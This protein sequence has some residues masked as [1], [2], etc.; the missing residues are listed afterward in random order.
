[1]DS[2]DKADIKNGMEE[3]SDSLMAMSMEQI[4]NEVAAQ[5]TDFMVALLGIPY[6]FSRKQPLDGRQRLELKEMIESGYYQLSE[7]IDWDSDATNKEMFEMKKMMTEYLP[8][9]LERINLQL[10]ADR[11]ATTADI[12]AWTPSTDEL[13]K[14]LSD[15]SFD[16]IELLSAVYNKQLREPFLQGMSQAGKRQMG[17]L[18]N[19]DLE[20]M[21]RR[22]TGLGFGMV[23]CGCDIM[24]S[25]A[26]AQNL[27]L[28]EQFT[29]LLNKITQA[30]AIP[31]IPS[32]GLTLRERLNVPERYL[33][34]IKRRQLTEAEAI[35][36]L[37]AYIT[38]DLQQHSQ[39][40]SRIKGIM[41]A[42]EKEKWIK[43]AEIDRRTQF[44]LLQRTFRE[45][46]QNGFSEDTFRKEGPR[47]Q[48]TAEEFREQLTNLFADI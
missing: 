11:Q 38:A 4:Q 10:P 1:M 9:I 37:L 48:K 17:A 31:A 19:S 21:S 12:I 26:K 41:S 36:K 39:R 13:F 6:A 30:K 33:P 40:C 45:L 14:L 42:L 27:P 18:W 34:I 29:V 22:L 23:E 47:E 44:R 3:M 35:D 43:W 8:Q 20:L 2:L 32:N 7:D 24:F 25:F 15:I 28:P 5:L 16:G 46:L